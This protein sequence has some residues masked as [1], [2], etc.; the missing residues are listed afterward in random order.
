MVLV[1]TASP[2]PVLMGRWLQPHALVL[3]VG[4]VGPTVRELD[5][6]TLHTSYIVAESRLAA[7]RES[8]DIVL[9]R[10]RV[11]AELGEILT[12]PAAAPTG[13]RVLFKSVGMA[14]EDLVAARLVWQARQVLTG[15]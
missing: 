11:Q 15:S 12:R 1:A 5:D 2:E 10:S 13:S 3:S 8:G 9:S 6:E 14:I 7:E 4:A